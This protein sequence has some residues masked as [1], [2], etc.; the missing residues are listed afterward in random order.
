MDRGVTVLRVAKVL[1]TTKITTNALFYVS[2]IATIFC[3]H[4]Y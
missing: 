4:L 3:V 1:E 2:P